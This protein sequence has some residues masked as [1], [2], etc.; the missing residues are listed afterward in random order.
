MFKLVGDD[1]FTLADSGVPC[2]ISVNPASGMKFTYALYVDG[3]PLQ[4]YKERQAKAWKTWHRTVADGTPYRIVLEKDT[5]NVFLNGELR[6]E[7]GE[8]AEEGGTDTEFARDGHVF[9]VSART[10]QV[11]REGLVYRAYV[12]EA[13]MEECAES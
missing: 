2:V 11:A 6:D 10:G 5:L 9:R 3:K 12:D 8:F 7:V 13:E 1:P 4:A